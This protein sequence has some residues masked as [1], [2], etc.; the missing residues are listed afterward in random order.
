L[1]LPVEALL[2][3]HGYY[4]ITTTDDVRVLNTLTTWSLEHDIPL[5]GLIASRPSL[6]DIYLSLVGAARAEGQPQE[7]ITTGATR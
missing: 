2:D 5:E 6:E 3:Q 4:E 1:A 7:P